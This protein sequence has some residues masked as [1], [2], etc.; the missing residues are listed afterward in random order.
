MVARRLA[1]DIVQ[2]GRL[3]PVPGLTCPQ[4]QVQVRV[5]VQESSVMVYQY[6][7]SPSQAIRTRSVKSPA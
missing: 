6:Q 3:L 7:S 2:A 5:Q 4:D 1:F